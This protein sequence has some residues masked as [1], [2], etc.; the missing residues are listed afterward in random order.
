M[1]RFMLILAMLLVSVQLH[2]QE[3]ACRVIDGDAGW[4]SGSVVMVSPTVDKDGNRE[5]L[6]LTANHVAERSVGISIE[7]QGKGRIEGA[8]V[9]VR[10]AFHDTMVILAKIDG[11]I[12]P[13]PLGKRPAVEGD[14]ITFVGKNFRKFEGT[15]SPLSFADRVW[16][17]TVVIPGDSGGA[18]LLDGCLI[19]VVSGGLD[20]TP[21]SPRRTWPCRA[22]NLVA[23][24]NLLELASKDV[25]WM[26]SAPLKIKRYA[27]GDAYVEGVQLFVFGATWCGPCKRLKA[28][29]PK[30]MGRLDDLG[31]DR[32]VWIDIDRHEDVSRQYKVTMI[33]TIVVLVDGN[34]VGRAYGV[35]T[36]GFMDMIKKSL[37]DKE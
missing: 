12:K 17:D 13:V 2:A 14:E 31:V 30:V 5:A 37:K 27:K 20:W 21:N 25:S 4:G 33:P 29:L 3:W 19:G 24:S 8:K 11:G 10:D 9:V 6:I 28:D 22:S 16:V 15:A 7:F 32:L 35:G 34:E 26:K 23:V 18:V 1:R 36:E